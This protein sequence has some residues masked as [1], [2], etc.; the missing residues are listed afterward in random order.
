M[1]VVMHKEATKAQVE[2][3]VHQ[4]EA[5]NFKAH[6]SEG[7]TATVIGVIGQNAIEIKD[8][9]VHLEGVAQIIPITKPFKLSGREWHPDDSVY[10]IGGVEIGGDGVFVM[11]GPCA[12]ESREQVMAT[13]E[14]VKSS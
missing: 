2:R 14:A 4:I 10:K 5:L 3:V 11:A 6:I 7:E 1:I 8:S 13:A 12:V 9:L